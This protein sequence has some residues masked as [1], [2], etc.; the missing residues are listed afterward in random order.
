[1]VRTGAPLVLNTNVA[2]AFNFPNY[3]NI[4]NFYAG[5]NNIFNA[6]QTD[7]NTGKNRDSN[8]IYGPNMPRTYFVG[9]KIK[10]P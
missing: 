5:V 8:Y 10:T 1:M 2:Y 6:Y 7:L 4:I 3:K 9:V